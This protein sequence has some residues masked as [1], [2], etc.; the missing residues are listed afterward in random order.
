MK[1]GR[2]AIAVD[3]GASSARFAAGWIEDGR[4]ELK[5]VKQVVHKPIKHGGREVWDVDALVSLCEEASQFGAERFE[6]CTIGVDSWGVDFG[7]LDASGEP[8]P[9]IVCYRDALH[10]RVFDELREYRK[11]LFQLTGIQ[12]QPFNTIYQLIARRRFGDDVSREWLFL[13]SW[14]LRRMGAACVSDVTMASTSQ[15]LKADASG[16]CERA[17]EIAGTPV[18]NANPDLP[19]GQ[20]GKTGDGLDIVQVG[21]H[22]TACAVHGL[23]GVQDDQAFLSLGTWSLLGCLED[24]PII[25]EEAENAGFSNER[26]IDGRVRFLTNVAGFFIVNRLHEELGVRE[27]I[28]EWIARADVVVE[29]VDLRDQRFFNPDSMSEA[30][31]E[32]VS[33]HPDTMER[34]AGVAILSI[35]KTSAQQ[36]MRLEKLVGRCFSSIR[37]CG[38]PSI[39]DSFCRLLAVET[40]K[41]VIVGP[42]EATIF[43]NLAQQLDADAETIGRSLNTRTYSPCD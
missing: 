1:G 31:L 2:G 21:G 41:T 22:D 25:S 29:P 37:A 16:W 34:W 7:F 32:S 14:L 5:I 13:P 40:G 19:R 24:A 17:F 18:P 20:V 8:S 26:A 28:D 10:A 3:L 39:N 30:I 23:G 12:H 6:E 15:L 35:A 43:G 36:L 42:Q 38:G 4:I 11:E 27:P 33:E 9:P